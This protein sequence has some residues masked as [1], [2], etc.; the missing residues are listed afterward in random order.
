MEKD[1]PGRVRLHM[2]EYHGAFGQPG[3]SQCFKGWTRQ[4]EK[5]A[6]TVPYPSEAR[7]LDVFQS[8]QQGNDKMTDPSYRPTSTEEGSWISHPIH[9][10]S[11]Y[12]LTFLHFFVTLTVRLVNLVQFLQLALRQILSLS[13]FDWKSP[14]IPF[15]V[16]RFISKQS[17]RF[18][19]GWRLILVDLLKI[20]P[21]FR[22]PPGKLV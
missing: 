10:K 22:V 18:T 8:Y 6:R 19:C 5:S 7:A 16:F 11:H 3:I 14:L 15:A 4:T 1:R 2:K 12:S 13:I 20:C 9:S 21:P 17:I